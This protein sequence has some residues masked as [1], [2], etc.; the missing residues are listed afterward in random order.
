[1]KGIV[2]WAYSECRSTLATY[3]E[4]IKALNIPGVVA[5]L[6]A[7]RSGCGMGLRT[8]TGFRA[9]EFAGMPID[10]VDMNREKGMSL[11]QRYRDWNH[12]FCDYQGSS[13]VRELIT[14]A[15]NAGMRVCVA[16]ESPCNMATGVMALLKAG[17]LKFFLN[18]R[19]RQVVRS[20]DFFVNY[21]GDDQ[22]AHTMAGWPMSKIVPFG[23]FP[24]PIEG[25]VCVRRISNNPFMILSTGILTRYR[26]ADILVQALILL[27]RRGVKYRAIITQDGPLLPLLKKVAAENQL[28]IEFPGFV[29]LPDLIKL[30]EECSVYVGVGR[31]EPWGMRLNDA[32]NC[33]AP[34]IVSDGMGGRKLVD[35]YG[36]GLVFKKGD[37]KDLCDKLERMATDIK[38]YKVCATKA[39]KAQPFISPEYNAHRLVDVFRQKG[40]M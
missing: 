28:P 4:L 9:D 27:K 1:M 32:L 16:T 7:S 3:R 6:H 2:I 24:P 35:D 31:S 13:L 12:M 8:K 21:S 29:Q 22:R 40:W 30:Y 15:H 19:M 10:V 34:L 5:I 23:Y 39:A 33:G 20:A 36:C 38:G 17:Y 37:P 26:G 25:S 11:I 14:T 18:I